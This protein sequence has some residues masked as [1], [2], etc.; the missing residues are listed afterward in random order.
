MGGTLI[1]IDIKEEFWVIVWEGMGI[2]IWG[3]SEVEV[4]LWVTVTSG[5]EVLSK[6]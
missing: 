2:V 1:P 3:V 6:T 4:L 5:V